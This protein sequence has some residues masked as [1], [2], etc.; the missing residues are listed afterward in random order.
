MNLTLGCL[1]CVRGVCCEHWFYYACNCYHCV[2]DCVCVAN[3]CVYDW[4]WMADVCMR[5]YTTFKY[6]LMGVWQVCIV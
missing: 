3:V 2:Y 6:N 4:I 1:V 5:L